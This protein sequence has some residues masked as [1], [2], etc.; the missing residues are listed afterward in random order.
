MSWKILIVMMFY[1]G[2]FFGMAWI[3]AH[4]QTPLPTPPALGGLVVNSCDATSVSFVAPKA[5]CPHMRYT[6]KGTTAT[7]W[8]I[9][10]HCSAT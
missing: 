1:L 8:V 2:P 10:Y 6:T 9:T 3:F 5:T 7:G 4:A